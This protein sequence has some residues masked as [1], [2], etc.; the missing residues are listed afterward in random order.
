MRWV[1]VHTEIHKGT[2]RDVNGTYRD[3]FIKGT[4][5]KYKKVQTEID[6]LGLTVR[7]EFVYMFYL[8]W[9]TPV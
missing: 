6:P 4:Y 5:W 8:C 3:A 7:A 1:K 2:H 9:L